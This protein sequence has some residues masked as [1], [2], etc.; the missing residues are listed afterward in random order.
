MLAHGRAQYA[1]WGALLLAMS[2]AVGLAAGINPRI[3]IGL[4]LGAAF[5]LV[6]ISDVTAGLVLF[7][8]LSFLGVINSASGG[9]ASFI[10]VAGLLLFGSWYAQRLVGTGRTR[11]AVARIPTNLLFCLVALATWSAISVTWAETSGVALTSTMSYVLNMLLFPIVMVAVRRREHLYWVLAAFVLGAVISTAYGFVSPAAGGS[12]GRLEGGIGDANEQAAVLVAAIP[13][14]IALGSAMR[15][16][17]LRYLSW[18]GGLFCLIG[19]F[20]T[21]SRGGLIA[22]G[23]VMVAAV[24]F[25]GRWRSKAAL[26]LAVTALGTVTYYFAIAPLAARERVT[27]SNSSG[28]TDIWRVGWRMV[29]AHPLTGVGSGNFQEASVHY[30]QG[31]GALTSAHLIVDVPHVAHNIYLELLADLGVPGLLA[32][33]GVAGFSLLAAATAA[34]RFERQGDVDMELIARS[35]V[36]SLV[37]FLSADFFLS[38]EF[39]K[40]L[41]LTFALCPAVLA[42]SRSSPAPARE[43]RTLPDLYQPQPTY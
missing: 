38:G 13:M 24:L 40:Q 8:T 39:S 26:L 3:G 41:W 19:V 15:R 29:Q 31:I 6:T 9:S 30:V 2:A 33:L 11:E 14:A 27:M 7:T 34:R 43:R 20:T 32:F 5:A 36:L 28:R 16:P 10:K 18:A 22:L 23:C 4:A 25:G 17:F 35:L 37:A 42:L 21:L 1:G 12:D